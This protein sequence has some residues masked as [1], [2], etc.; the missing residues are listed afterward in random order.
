MAIQ[1]IITK[2]VLMV[3]YSDIEGIY[4]SLESGYVICYSRTKYCLWVKGETTGYIVGVYRICLD[5]DKDS[6]LIGSLIKGN[7][8]HLGNYSCFCSE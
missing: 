7:T 6:V 1:D 4:I 2:D 8:C 3:G 5:C